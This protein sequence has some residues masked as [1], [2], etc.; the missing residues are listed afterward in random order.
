[1]TVAFK[2]CRLSGKITAPPSKSFAHRALICAS[3]TGGAEVRGIG[4]SEDVSATLSCLRA[5]GAKAEIKGD[6]VLIGGLD[7]FDIP[8]GAILDCRESGSTLRFL[9]P[10]C[11][12][13]GKPVVLTGSKRLFERP[14]GVYK[15]ICEER[16]WTFE[17]KENGLA[18]CGDLSA[19]DYC[20]PGNISSQF[21]TGLMLALPMLRGES[22][23][24]IAG[25]FESASYADIT[26][27]VM[28]DFGVSV[29]KTADGF[30]VYG[31]RSYSRTEPYTVEGDCS[32]AA[33]LEAFNLAGGNVEVTGIKEDTV[34]GDRVYKSIF[35]GF[36]NGEKRF[37]LSDCPDLAPVAFAASLP[38]GGAEFTGTARLR[39]KESDRAECMRK[40]LCKFGA[41]VTVNENSVII[42]SNG[43]K[44]P[45]ETLCSHNDHRI[46]MALS[47]LC[48]VTGGSIE[49]AEAV[50]KSYP[51]FFE[52]I[53]KLGA[54]IE[55]TE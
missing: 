10:I 45:S 52:D 24:R 35:A 29:D 25:G 23:I 19:G 42:N 3:L 6:S 46:A 38:F 34:Q 16:G 20:A 22:R 17:L 9:I 4:F 15:E 49:G 51:G 39:L 14:L 5:L 18:L 30:R 12:T 32:N 31:D 2:P 44:T 27:S 21:V 33:F 48:S 54:I 7:P 8:D 36:E 47:L 43:V 28:R 11:L 37:D 55:E 40:E 13:A 1:M 26:A 50:K 53:K 41:S